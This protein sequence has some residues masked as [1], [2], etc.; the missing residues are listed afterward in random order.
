MKQK[1]GTA[2]INYL[3][4]LQKQKE[5]GAL[6]I[7]NSLQ[8]E[9]PLNSWSNLRIEEQRFIFS[10]RSEMNPLKSNF[11]RN[12]KMEVEFCIKKFRTELD[13]EH[14]VWC[15]FINEESDYRYNDILNGNLQD[16]VGTFKQIQIN[17]EIRKE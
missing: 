5:K 12:N 4:S 3:N 15:K 10:V 2:A 6:I 9:N 13:N 11:K 16:K 1:A 8:L 17:E 7:Y 14:L